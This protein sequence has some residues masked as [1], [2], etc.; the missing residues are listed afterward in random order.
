MPFGHR[1]PRKHDSRFNI[2]S[3]PSGSSEFSEH[4]EF[5][6]GSEWAD[7]ARRFPTVDRLADCDA[8]EKCQR[9]L[10]R[11]DARAKIVDG[12]NNKNGNCTLK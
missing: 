9:A 1:T 10:V 12:E 4:S 3:S 2:A 6:E 8:W 5:S 7:T 11:V